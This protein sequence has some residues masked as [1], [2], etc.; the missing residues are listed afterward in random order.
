MILTDELQLSKIT[1]SSL[2]KAEE[3]FDYI[4]DTLV[5]YAIN[6]PLRIA[7]F[8]AQVSHES[9]SFRYT[10]ELATGEQYEG[11]KDLGNVEKGDGIKFK[12]RGLIQITGRTNYALYGKSVGIDFSSSPSLLAS[13]EFAT[14]SAGWFWNQH[15]L[16]ELADANKLI[17]ITKRINGGLN[18]LEDR[19]KRL[20]SA[21]TILNA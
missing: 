2:E 12:G 10:E 11:R 18:G 13:P 19:Q 16:N 3:Y 8:L 21:K 9:G 20:V 7:H 17:A 15:K 14:D 6:T 1:L 4:N 5:K